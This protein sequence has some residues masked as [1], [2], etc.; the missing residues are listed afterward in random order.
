VEGDERSGHPE[1]HRTNENVEKV[2]NSAHSIRHLIIRAMA[3]QLI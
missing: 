1:Y 3:V 2:W